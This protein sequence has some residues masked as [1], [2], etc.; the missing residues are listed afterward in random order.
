MGTFSLYLCQRKTQEIL[1]LSPY[2]LLTDKQA[3]ERILLPEERSYGVSAITQ[4]I[5]GSHR[6]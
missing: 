6:F 5:Q 1:G 3:L 4:A 2:E